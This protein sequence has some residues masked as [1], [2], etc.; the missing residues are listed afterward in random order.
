MQQKCKGSFTVEAAFLVPFTG[1][2][3]IL[4]IYTAMYLRDVTVAKAILQKAAAQGADFAEGNVY[5]D[6]DYVLYQRYLADGFFTSLMRDDKD[7]AEEILL[8]DFRSKAEGRLWVSEIEEMNVSVDSHSVKVSAAVCGNPAS[9]FGFVGIGG[10]FFRQELRYE[11]P[12]SELAS[13]S[14]IATTV[15]QTGEKIRGVKTVM[16]K[17]TQFFGWIGK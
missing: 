3:L 7:D 1:I 2:L 4:M 5:P 8:D 12:R 17:I 6:T 10:G 11:Y 14:R 16:N 15:L 9:G 13:W